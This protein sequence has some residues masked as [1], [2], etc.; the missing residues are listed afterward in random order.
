MEL[1]QIFNYVVDNFDKH[2][3]ISSIISSAGLGTIGTGIFSF[4]RRPKSS[5]QKDNKYFKNKKLLDI[6]TKRPAYSDRMAYVMAEMSD[7]AYF[8]FE[9]SG[10][11]ILDAVK[12]VQE[13]NTENADQVKKFL[14]SYTQGLMGSRDLNIDF[15]IEILKNSKFDLLDTIDIGETQGFACKYIDEKQSPYVVIAFRGTEK[16]I[17]DWLTDLKAIPTAVGKGKVHTG[18]YEAFTNI[19][20]AEGMTVYDKIKQIMQSPAANDDKGKPLPLFFTGHS[21]GGALALLATNLLAKDIKGACYTFGGPRI[22]DYEFLKGLKTPVYRVVNSS[23]IVPRVPPGAITAILL[24]LIKLLSSLTQLVPLISSIFNKIENFLD[25][26]NGYRH[27]GDLR[28][29]TDIDAKKFDTVRLLSNP[30]ALDRIMWMWQHLVASVRYPISSHSITIYR[31][32]LLYIAS[33]RFANPHPPKISDD[34]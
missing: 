7:L 13:L 9:G 33:D 29:L 19:T 22:A 2:P 6:P 4:K 5:L 34:N 30:P 24:N 28:Y 14:E 8:E 20:D 10:G 12:R 16:K 15:L 25:K 27:V 17:S 18:F 23:D 11:A 21:L 32:K 3:W 1:I 26:L 31:K